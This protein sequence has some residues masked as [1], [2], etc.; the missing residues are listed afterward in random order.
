MNEFLQNFETSRSES[1]IHE[2]DDP[3][4]QEEIKR[5]AIQLKSNKSCSLDNIMNEY[6]KECIDVLKL[7]LETVFN[8]ILDKKSFLKQWATYI[9]ERRQ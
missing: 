4:T 5:A 1:T 6:S 8:Y 7:P 2:L 3:I 9:Q